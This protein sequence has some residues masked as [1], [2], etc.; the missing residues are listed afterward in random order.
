MADIRTLLDEV[1]AREPR[2]APVDEVH[3]AVRR[4]AARHAVLTAAAAIAAVA[5]GVATVNAAGR[6]AGPVAPSP[7]PQPTFGGTTGIS[8]FIGQHPDVFLGG[9]TTSSDGVTEHATVYVAAGVDPAE[10][11]DEINAHG[12][13]SVDWRVVRCGATRARYDEI[14]RE[15]PAFRWPS[16]ATLLGNPRFQVGNGRC[17][18]ELPLPHDTGWELDRAAAQERWGRDVQVVTYAVSHGPL[19]AATL[20]PS[21]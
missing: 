11:T 7:T 2:P 5:L 16:G 8:M 21:P 4:R 6:D 17:R 20:S 3:A 19:P 14:M 9:L 18:V 15:A 1:T 13:D 12:G 10:W